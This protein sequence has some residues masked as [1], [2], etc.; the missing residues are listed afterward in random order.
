MCSTYTHQ[1]VC[2]YVYIYI[3]GSRS[4][5]L[6]FQMGRCVCVKVILSAQRPYQLAFMVVQGTTSHG[7]R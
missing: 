1:D 3:L 5:A 4:S 6:G 2:I 7:K